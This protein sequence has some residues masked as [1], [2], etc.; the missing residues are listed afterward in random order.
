MDISTYLDNP[1]QDQIPNDVEKK[2]IMDISTHPDSLQDQQQ[3]HLRRK[4]ERKTD[5]FDD[6]QSQLD[7]K[8]RGW[9]VIQEMGKGAH[10]A[11][12]KI[13][14]DHGDIYVIKLFSKAVEKDFQRESS[15]LAMMKHRSNILDITPSLFGNNTRS[16]AFELREYFGI[17]LEAGFATL[18]QFRDFLR[19]QNKLLTDQDLMSLLDALYSC[20][21]LLHSINVCH[22]DIKPA[23]IVL[24]YYQKSNNL[25][26]ELI[27]FSIA[28]QESHSTKI[29]S[30]GG[31]LGYISP[32]IMQCR[33]NKQ[34]FSAD[35]LIWG[36]LFSIGVIM[37]EF[38]VPSYK[39]TRQYCW[40]R[41]STQRAC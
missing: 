34:G 29:S 10:G 2:N 14:N 41:I 31:T 39:P 21:F 18:Q 13:I 28:Q 35:D 17:V 8:E 4:E 25:D 5:G 15:I 37:L 6:I 30:F 16:A 11:V 20:Y 40:Y 24:H 33:D 32:S 36:D 22:R 38:A 26:L 12:Y 19:T 27:D 3:S 7:E 9:R 23:N 1:L